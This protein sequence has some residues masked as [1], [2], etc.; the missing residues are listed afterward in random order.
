MTPPAKGG[1]KRERERKG[2]EEGERRQSFW[3]I[4]SDQWKD[5]HT[6]LLDNKILNQ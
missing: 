5:Q 1:L 4:D 3:D 2:G 6:V